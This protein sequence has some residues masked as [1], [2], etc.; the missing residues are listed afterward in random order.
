MKKTGEY[1]YLIF[2]GF[3]LF[4]AGAVILGG[5]SYF[6]DLYIGFD[7]I[8]VILYYV[9]SMFLTRQV[10]KGIEIRGKA[11]SIILPLYTALMCIIK[12]FV[13]YIIILMLAGNGF[14]ESLLIIPYTYLMDIISIFGNGFSMDGIFTS[15]INIL[16]VILDVAIMIIG[17]VNSYRVTVRE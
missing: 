3:L 5:I 2:I 6:I 4:M 11:V 15:L 10:L 16:I 17:V 13:V 9:F 7:F 8:S 14:F 1:L 12:E